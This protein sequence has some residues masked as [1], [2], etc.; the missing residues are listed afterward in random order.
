VASGAFVVASSVAVITV[1]LACAGCGVGGV[2]VTLFSTANR[3]T[4]AGRTT[5]V[6]TM[7]SCALVV[8]QAL[9]T[10]LG[11]GVSETHGSA[12][13]FLMAAATAG[14]LLLA[15]LAS[16]AMDRRPGYGDS[17]SGRS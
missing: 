11:G 7:L 3:R 14:A 17:R 1:L 15:G 5:T 12:A 9:W 4:P 2:I 6:M 10:A 13:G 16:Y 8:G